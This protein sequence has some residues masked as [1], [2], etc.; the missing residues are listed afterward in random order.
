MA[1]GIEFVK[2]SGNVFAD[3]GLANPEERLAKAKLLPVLKNI[4]EE[5]GLTQEEVAG[6]CGVDQPTISKA[7]RGKM[8]NIS[9]ER[10]TRWITCLGS[11]VEI[12][13]KR[14]A[15]EGPGKIVIREETG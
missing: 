5:R 15:S 1:E 3:L 9:L 8:K 11:D 4:I 13:V 6:M 7:L 14:R 10:L 12:F 2:G